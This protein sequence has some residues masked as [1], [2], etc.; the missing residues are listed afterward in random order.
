MPL[1]LSLESNTKELCE[2]LHFIQDVPTRPQCSTFSRANC[3]ASTVLVQKGKPDSC[4]CTEALL[5]QCVAH[6]HVAKT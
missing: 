5:G 3:V 2:A 4:T 6:T 1:M